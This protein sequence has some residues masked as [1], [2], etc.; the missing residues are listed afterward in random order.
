MKCF[1]SLLSISFAI[2]LQYVLLLTDT[3][4]LSQCFNYDV[5]DLTPRRKQIEKL[6]VQCIE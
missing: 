6:K 4:N 2:I 3:V 5:M 1:V